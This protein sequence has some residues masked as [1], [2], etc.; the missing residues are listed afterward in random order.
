VHDRLQERLGREVPMI[1][2][3]QYPTISALS[4][5]LDG[6]GDTAPRPDRAQERA[7]LQRRALA[8]QKAQRRG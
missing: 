7:E 2:L 3:F 6:A 8:R 5:H 4:R 1:D